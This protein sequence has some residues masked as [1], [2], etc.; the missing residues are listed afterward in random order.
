MLQPFLPDQ[1]GDLF[2]H[3]GFIDLVRDLGKD[4]LGLSLAG[5]FDFRLGSDHYLS[6][7][8][9][10]CHFCA[11]SAHDDCTGRKIGSLDDLDQVFDIRVGYVDKL[12]RSVDD[13]AE[14]VRRNG[15]GHTDRDAVCPVHQKVRE[16]GGK[17]D[18]FLLLLIKIW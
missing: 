9:T 10:I 4:D 3:S 13:V 11:V 18:R 5:F 14:I 8:G 2:D 16:T 12:H 17:N 1:L 6:K 7:S 15:S